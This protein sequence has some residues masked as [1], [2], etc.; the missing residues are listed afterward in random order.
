M[1]INFIYLYSSTVYN[2]SECKEYA[3]PIVYA[4]KH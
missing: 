1:L 3:V 2:I 4:L